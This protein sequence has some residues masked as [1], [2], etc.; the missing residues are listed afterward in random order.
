MT[1]SV[2][3]TAYKEQ[4]SVVKAIK[5]VIQSNQHILSNTQLIVVCGDQLTYE[6]ALSTIT[7]L[8]FTN[9]KVLKDNAEG[10]AEALNLA[11]KNATGDIWVMTD[12]DMY[13]SENA[14]EK[15]VL[16]FINAEVVGVTG[17]I[18]SIDNKEL[19]F[20]YYS[21]V[22]TQAAN[23][24]RENKQ[25]KNLFF[26]LSGYLY[27]IRK[28]TGLILSKDLRAEDAYISHF[29]YKTGLSFVYVNDAIAYVQFPK[30]LND[31]IKQK[32]RSLG[33]NIQNQKFYSSNKRSI[34]QD[35][36]MLTFPLSYAK[37]FR[38]FIY[39]LLIY[40]LR[41]YLWVVIYF[42]H[43]FNMYNSGRWERIESSK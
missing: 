28:Q 35:L 4:D 31:L 42:R 12:G 38:Q 34:G 18:T 1:Y 10:K 32:I 41:L 39:S 33:G 11:F 37:S 2:I 20:G 9:Y 36:Q 6:S 22:F 23:L 29:V 27:A 13:L 14:V 19:F 5:S 7:K 30:N 15:I 17:N 25:K 8:N 26:P 24:Y 16:K 43:S 21:H 40:P 3:I